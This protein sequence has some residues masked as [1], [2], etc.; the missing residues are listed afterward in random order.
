MLFTYNNTTYNFNVKMFWR[1]G[2]TPIR[3]R[4]TLHHINFTNKLTETSYDHRVSRYHLVFVM[5]A[6]RSS[7]RVAIHASATGKICCYILYICAW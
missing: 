6:E 3:S 5:C 2:D 1:T 7:L 4:D